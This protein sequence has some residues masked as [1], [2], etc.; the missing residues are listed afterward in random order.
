MLARYPAVAL[1]ACLLSFSAQAQRSLESLVNEANAEWMFGNWQAQT[2]NGDTLTLNI[3]WDLEKHV[4]M[5]HV[6][7][8]DMESKGYTVL[9]PKAE[10]PKYYAFD[11]RGSVSKGSW[12]MENGDLVLRVES[13]VPDRGPRKSAFVFSG[14]AS[15]GL[16]VAMHDVD[17]SG[18][19]ATS[20]R[21]TLK[22]KKQA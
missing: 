13:E 15:T 6:K 14:S 2:D 17:S 7:A 11:N 18:E 5:L 22:F 21:M 9:E 20:A 1:C 16:Q 10:M 12:N 3:S 4:V 19:L 8:N